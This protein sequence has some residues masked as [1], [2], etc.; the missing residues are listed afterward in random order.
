MGVV[1]MKKSGIALIFFITCLFS[2]LYS[3][4]INTLS[5]KDKFKVDENFKWYGTGQ[6]FEL[7]YKVDIPLI[8]GCAGIYFPTLIYEEFF[9]STDIAFDGTPL[10]KEEINPFDRALLFPY[11]KKQDV[12]ADIISLGVFASPAIIMCMPEVKLDDWLTITVMYAETYILTRGFKEL[13]KLSLNRARPYMYFDNYPVGEVE[14]G[15]WYLSFPSGHTA[16][17]FAT[18]AFLSAAS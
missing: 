15:D 4:D 11:S 7:S 14:R 6:P 2:S 1:Q 8:V 16:Y 5:F 3:Q 12:I 17:A 10:N 18:A 9:N 13:L